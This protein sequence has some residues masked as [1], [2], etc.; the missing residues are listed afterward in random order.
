M[1]AYYRYGYGNMNMDWPFLFFLGA[2]ILSFWASIKVRSNY[3]KFSKVAV[4]SGMTGAEVAKLILN[5]QGIY[6]VTVQ[7]VSGNLTDHYD[8]RNKTVRLSEGVYDGTSISAVSI[9]AHE[10]GHAIQHNEAYYFL[11]FR[12][13]L[14]PIV[15]FTSNFVFM[16]IIAG[17]IL[18]ITSLVNLGIILFSLT[19]LFQI[20]TLPVEFDASNRAL[21]CLEDYRVITQDEKKGSKKVLGAAALTYVAAALVSLAQLLRFLNMRRD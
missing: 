21:R 1:L 17:F 9:A 16:L 3:S 18:Q 19:L 15:S 10:I 14:A 5:R 11:T 8:P 4:N 13:A 2:M 12:S 7:E 6:D 20:I